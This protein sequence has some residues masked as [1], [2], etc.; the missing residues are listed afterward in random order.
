M[1]RQQLC[2]RGKKLEYLMYLYINKEVTKNSHQSVNLE[3][4]DTQTAALAIAYLARQQGCFHFDEKCQAMMDDL[5]LA[6]RVKADLALNSATSHL[7]FDV[8]SQDRCITISG[9]LPSVDF[10]NEVKRVASAVPGVKEVSLDQL[11]SPTQA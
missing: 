11:L 5:A 2:Q 8:T 10:V 9:K 7:E 1:I 6:S 4:M 3:K